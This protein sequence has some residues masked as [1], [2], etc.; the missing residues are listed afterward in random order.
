MHSFRDVDTAT[1]LLSFGRSM[2]SS[3][4]CLIFILIVSLSIYKIT[5]DRYFFSALF[6][7]MQALFRIGRGQPPPVPESL[8]KDARDFIH[9]CLQVNPNKRPTAAQLL[10]HPFVKRR[11]LS[12]LLSPISPVSP[13][14]NLL[15]S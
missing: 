8:S 10:D 5:D 14:I 11:L 1:S 9:R 2:S 13:R 7:Q 15:L 4:L 12:P 6:Q 3:F